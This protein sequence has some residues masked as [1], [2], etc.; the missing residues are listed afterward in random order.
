M[1]SRSVLKLLRQVEEWHH[2]LARET[3]TPAT[4]WER[5]AIGELTC[6]ERD[7]GGRG[8]QLTWSIREILTTK[9]LNAEGRA[10]HHCVR[11]YANSCRKGKTAIFSLQLTDSEGA[12]TRLMTI[13]ANPGTRMLACC[14]AWRLPAVHGRSF[15]PGRSRIR[16][17]RS[18]IASITPA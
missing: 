10:M 1:K 14:G 16:S 3:R 7:E 6:K 12:S 5:S 8:Q 2:Q 4:Q 18:M 13:A 17:G 11:S 15:S 9:E